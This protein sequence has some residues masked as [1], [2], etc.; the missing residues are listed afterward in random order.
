MKKY[1]YLLLV[2]LSFLAV[3]CEESKLETWHGKNYLHFVPGADGSMKTRYNF[4]AE[5]TTDQTSASV[6]LPVEIWG[7]MAE[8]DFSLSV[9]INGRPVSAAFRAGLPIDTLW[10]PV[11]RDAGLLSTSYAVEVEITGA[12][13]DYEVSPAS[14]CKA[15]IW[16]E[17]SLE[18]LQPAWWATT[19][20]LGPYS[21]LKFRLFNIFSRGFVR[22]IDN[23]TAIE[24][25]RVALEFREW[26][27]GLWDAGQRYYDVDGTSPLYESIPL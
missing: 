18:G 25:K 14:Y 16:V 22:S 21:P 13:S 15:E 2:A 23:Y 9:T 7:F 4:A 6:P 12:G 20:A 17:D 5:G 11:T 8:D 10:V 26:L 3:S 24:F 19:P 1:I 27:H